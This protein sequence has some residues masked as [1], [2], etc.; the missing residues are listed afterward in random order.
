MAGD[1][2][3]EETHVG[4]HNYLKLVM[5]VPL[6]FIEIALS[7]GAS[8]RRA[9][10]SREVT[11]SP[12]MTAVDEKSDIVSTV[13]Q[14]K[15]VQTNR[16]PP[17]AHAAKCARPRISRSAL[18]QLDERKRTSLRNFR[19]SSGIRCA[20]VCPSPPKAIEPRAER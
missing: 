14:H 19:I 13:F 8:V 7:C 1:Q 12:K 11:C 15:D 6:R 2:E 18:H 5:S 20:R 17:P 4:R 9:A 16:L 10:K 3:S